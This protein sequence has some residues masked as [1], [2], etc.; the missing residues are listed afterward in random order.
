VPRSRGSSV[1]L[2]HLRSVGNAAVLAPATK[3]RR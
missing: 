3:N 1:E 2:R